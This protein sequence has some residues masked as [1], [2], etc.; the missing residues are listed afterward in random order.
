MANFKINWNIFG[1]NK[2]SGKS[3]EAA[4]YAKTFYKFLG[5]QSA[6]YDTDSK[7][8]LYEGYG[9]NPDVY[10]IL[11]QQADKTKV[12]PYYIRDIKDEKSYS[13]LMS[14]QTAT[15][16]DL[17]IKQMATKLMLESKAYSEDEMKFPL[18]NPNPLQTWSEV[19][20]LWKIFM[21]TTGNC[22]FY[23]PKPSSGVNRGKPLGLYVLPSHMM[24]I[25]MKENV[26]EFS[27]QSPISH[28]MLIDNKD[29]IE[30]Q[31]DDIIHTKYPNPFY[32]F[33][34][35]QLYGLSPMR[36]IIRNLESS[37]EA[38]NTN[39]KTMKNGGV[40]GFITGKDQVLT[41]DHAT[42]LKERLQE[43]DANPERLS[44]IA[45][46]SVPIEFTKLSVNPSDLMIFDYLKYDRKTIANALGWSDALL[47]NDD[48]G[49]YDKQTSE[50][51]RV[52]TDNILP[53]LILLQ[54][55]LT[56]GFVRKFPGYENT[57]MDFDITE[58]PEMQEDISKLVEWMDKAPL[59]YNEKRLAINYGTKDIE[60]MD[61]IWIDS[62]KKRID[63][64]G[65][66]MEDL[67]KSYLDL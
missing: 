52:I 39:V 67:Q 64:M 55:A 46:L 32:D 1:T 44:K 36:A 28:Y 26:S 9:N 24:K 47:N 43:M 65:I 29:F 35:S 57:Y 4:P 63:E 22:Y 11:Q 23:V 6:Q 56:R 45:G 17:S 5:N 10:A 50:K 3:S 16:G 14:L 15:K 60:G 51:R 61:T 38:L 42:Q 34:G 19:F 21:K 58:L 41:A 37:N 59:T 2:D 62:S 66:T 54:E 20:A 48:G 30:F 33:R 13:K 40:F 31:A 25:V 53:D 18:E 12:I 49:K 27:L 7:T 8:Y